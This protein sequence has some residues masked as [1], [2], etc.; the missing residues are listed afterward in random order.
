MVKNRGGTKMLGFFSAERN[1][2][3]LIALLKAHNIRKI[4]ASPGTT[5]VNFVGSIEND[6]FFEIYSCVDERSA[7][8]MACGL[9]EETGEPV[10]I[11]CTGAT[12]SRNYFSGL[13]E[14]YYRKL[15]ILAVTGMQ[16]FGKIGSLS[17]QVIDRSLQPRDTVKLSVQIPAVFSNDDDEWFANVQINRAILELTHNGGGPV[18]IDLQTN[19]TVESCEKPKTNERV[20]RRVYYTDPFPRIPTGK[21]GI[22]VGAHGKWTDELTKMVDHFCAC[23]DSVVLCDNTSN[24]WGKFKAQ[25][26]LIS[27]QF[28]SGHELGQFDLIIHL[29]EVSGTGIKFKTKEVWRVSPDGELRDTFRKLSYVFEMREES[30]FSHFE[31]EHESDNTD[32]YNAWND[33]YEKLL[34]KIPELPFSNIWVAQHTIGKLPERSV[35]HFGI[36]NSLRS[37]SY[38]IPSKGTLC[39]CNTGGFGIDGGI[40][41]LIGASFADL[42]TPYFGVVGDLSFFYDMNS[43]GNRHVGNNLR[44]LVINNGCGVQFHLSGNYSQKV[45]ISD[46]DTHRFIAAGGHFGNMSPDLV[47][48]YAQDLGFEYICARTKEEFTNQLELYV[49]PEIGSKPI[50]FEVFVEYHD[51]AKADSLIR[52]L[53]APLS[54]GT[55]KIAQSV[56]GERNVQKIKRFIKH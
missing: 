5:N 9:A 39:Y 36:L 29:G 41:S 33:E 43:I 55:R 14:A 50:L 47:R 19:F 15:P 13:T 37:W 52:S 38:F 45:G 35:L 28:G 22:F 48:H 56:I 17:A 6:P 23:H 2:Q 32:S 42:E 12:A 34:G 7:A 30:F 8:Y 18:H 54:Y 1:T 46:L 49:S 10:V 16:H 31:Q 51:D 27:A 21:I 20:I 26:P 4:I 24:Y 11:T 3:M 25:A 40:S 44:L 53:E